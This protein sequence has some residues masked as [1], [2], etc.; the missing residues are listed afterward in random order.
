MK[1]AVKWMLI[2]GVV[3]TFG[4]PFTG[5]IFTAIGMIGAFHTLGQNGISDPQV[6][7]THIGGALVATAAG[8][9]VAV[10]LG[11]PLIVIAMILHFATREST[12]ARPA[13]DT[14]GTDPS[15]SSG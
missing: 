14:H 9:I 15:T 8:L 4:A 7:S 10:I 3:C 12:A 2:A 5:L 1:P 11:V 6:L 13:A